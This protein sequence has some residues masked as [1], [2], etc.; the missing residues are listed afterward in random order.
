MV[1]MLLSASS[2]MY[3][4]VPASGPLGMLQ[5]PAT[6]TV[7]PAPVH[8]GGLHSMGTSL[9][10]GHV[11]AGE[12]GG[13]GGGGGGRGVGL[14]ACGGARA[15]AARPSL[16]DLPRPVLRGGGG[17]GGGLGR[18]GGAAHSARRTGWCRCRSTTRGR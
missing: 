5:V 12:G 10:G 1:V 8:T 3:T 13:R 6:V 4:G 9:L 11:G 16:R 15:R 7:E 14:R 17:G 18:G 2:Y